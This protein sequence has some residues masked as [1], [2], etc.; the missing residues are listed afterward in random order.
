MPSLKAQHFD[1]L[2]LAISSAMQGLGVTIGDLSLI[3]EDLRAQRIITPFSLCVPSGASYYLIYPERPA[4]SPVLQEFAQ[5]LEG[6]AAV[7]RA[8]LLAYMRR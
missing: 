2:D 7:T 3:E 4:P 8:N 1:T 6:E 5:W